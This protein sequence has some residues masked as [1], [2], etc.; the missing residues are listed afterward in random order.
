MAKQNNKIS[1]AISLTLHIFV[2][3]GLL[4]LNKPISVLTPSRSD[5]IEVSLMSMPPQ[6]TQQDNIPIKAEQPEPIK[7]IDTPAEVNLKPSA[8]PEKKVKPIVKPTPLKPVVK[9]TIQ[10]SPVPSPVKEAP[11]QPSKVVAKIKPI[12]K[13]AQINDLL[14]DSL[15][16]S[17]TSIRKGKALGGNPNGTSDSNNLNS[18]YADQVI[19]MVR[20]FVQVPPDVN[21]KAKAI[22]RVELYPNMNVKSVK[23]IK[24][25]GS[26][27]YDQNIQT[28]IMRAK[29]FP[30]LPDGANFVDYRILNLTF[31]PE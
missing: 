18:N 27:Q 9:P 25:S 12:N 19:N 30:N 2:G 16:N 11:P 20:P 7:T 28:A 8:K 24:S 1:T 21:T 13:K 6:V 22:V 15:T 17:N 5:G 3:I 23:L 26:I 29:V 31:R 14:G 4:V 10:P